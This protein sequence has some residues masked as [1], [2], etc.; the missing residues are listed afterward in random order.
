MYILCEGASANECTSRLAGTRAGMT[1]LVNF[2]VHGMWE[3]C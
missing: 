3:V 1:Q 2:S